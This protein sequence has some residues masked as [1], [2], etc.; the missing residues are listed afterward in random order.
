MCGAGSRRY[1]VDRVETDA[2]FD[3]YLEGLL[4]E[5]L[6]GRRVAFHITDKRSGRAAGG[7]SFCNMVET[8]RRLEIGRAWLGREFRG[9]SAAPPS[10]RTTATRRTPA[11]R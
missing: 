2:D 3:T 10:T 6:S 9:P 1:T 8:A 5:H 7:R 4:R 11:C